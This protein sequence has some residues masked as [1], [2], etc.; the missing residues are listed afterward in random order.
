VQFV[1]RSLLE[2]AELA[3]FRSKLRGL[4]GVQT[5]GATPSGKTAGAGVP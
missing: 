2:G 3:A 1:S 4:L 5:A